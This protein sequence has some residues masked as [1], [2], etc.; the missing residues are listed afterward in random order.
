V[1]IAV[2]AADYRS[3]NPINAKKAMKVVQLANKNEGCDD[4][5]DTPWQVHQ[6]LWK[7]GWMIFHDDIIRFC[8][9]RGGP[10]TV[11]LVT[12]ITLS[13]TLSQSSNNTMTTLY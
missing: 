13:L 9:R 4:Q 10:L 11:A 7:E 1:D 5:N 3:L 2:S 12:I 8:M 6:R